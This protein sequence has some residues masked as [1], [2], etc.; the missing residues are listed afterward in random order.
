MCF[1][2]SGK[3]KIDNESLHFAYIQIRSELLI[4]FYTEQ[5]TNKP[6][7]QFPG[8]NDRTETFELN[9]KYISTIY[10]C[11]LYKKTIRKDYDFGFVLFFHALYHLLSKKCTLV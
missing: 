11:Y 9:N 7:L 8:C 3:K 6:F 1:V 5:N 4:F 2:K 10:T